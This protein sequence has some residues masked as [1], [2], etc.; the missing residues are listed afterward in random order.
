MH[1]IPAVFM[2]VCEVI[3]EC[4]FKLASSAGVSLPPHHSPS[5][6]VQH[7]TRLLAPHKTREHPPLCNPVPI[8]Q[9][10]RAVKSCAP[11][12]P[13]MTRSTHLANP[14]P[15]ILLRQSVRLDL[16]FFLYGLGDR[17]STKTAPISTNLGTF[18]TKFG[19]NLG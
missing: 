5:L 16:A 19:T 10:S 2:G 14:V 11:N 15:R 8:S 7:T 3:E 18:G 6:P 12:T 13:V 17:F 9:P 4:S 1:A